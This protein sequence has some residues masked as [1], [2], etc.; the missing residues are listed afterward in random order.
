[1]RS[2]LIN[3][4]IVVILFFSIPSLVFAKS[5]IK[6][7]TLNCNSSYNFS[8]NG[9]LCSLGYIIDQFTEFTPNIL[10]SNGFGGNLAGVAYNQYVNGTEAL[11]IAI[12]PLIIY[13]YV[14]HLIGEVSIGG[15][16]FSPIDL[17]YNIIF[18]V[19]LLF[20]SVY[21]MSFLITFINIID[22]FIVLHIISSS[23]PSLFQ[24]IVNSISL[25][26]FSSGLFTGVIIFILYILLLIALFI[27][28]FQ[29]IL[30]F[31]LLWILILLFP[32]AIV[33]SIYPPFN[34][35]LRN[36]FSK[37][38]ELL[39]VQPAFLIGVS[40]FII[41]IKDF[42]INPIEKFILG[43]VTLFALSLVPTLLNRYLNFSISSGYRKV[44][45]VINKVK[46]L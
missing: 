34:G 41:I 14:M 8:V 29:F 4:T 38:A 1:M 7:S 40:I 20:L 46:Y 26:S 27:F 45:R 17:L 23:T 32:F 9:M 43:I 2:Y 15:T 18:S 44:R 42:S 13:I 31:I 37:I 5:G 28:S 10:S 36:I 6:A 12:I 21:I 22:K 33:V 25:S 24:T 11:S 16:R 35:V 3:I 19:I 30:R 39:F